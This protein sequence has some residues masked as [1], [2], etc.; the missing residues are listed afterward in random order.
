MGTKHRCAAALLLAVFLLFC[1]ACGAAPVQPEDTE[2]KDQYMTDPVP[3]GKPAP[4]E[5]QDVV[6]DDDAELTCTF[7]ISCATILDN[8]DKC[9]DSKKPLVPADGVIL[10]STTVTLFALIPGVAAY[11]KTLAMITVVAIITYLSLII[12]ELVPKSIALNNPERWA[13]M[14]SP[15]MIVL[16]K[17]SYPFVCLLSASTKLMNKLIGLNSGEERQMTQ[18]ELKMIL[19]QSSEQG[20]IDKDETEM[21]RDVFRFSDKRA[22]DLMTYRRDIVVLHPTD[23]PEEVLRIIHEEHFSKYLLVERGKDE[24]IGVVSVKDIILMMGGEQPFNLRSIARPALF[25]PESLYAKKVLELF[26]KNKNKF[27]VVVDEYGNTEGIITLHDLTESI[28]GDILEENETEEEEIVVRQDGSMLVEASMNLD[29]FMEAMGIMNYDDLKEE[30]FTTLSGLAMF[31][32]GQV[33]KAGDLFSYKNLDF[34]VVDMDRG[35]VDK[36]LVI[37]KE[38]DE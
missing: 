22:N 13:T 33:P 3:E 20:V 37:K 8:W 30:D 16:T 36:L 31:L 35:R 24:I 26:K 2:N 6:R 10:P 29:D 27:G 1:T 38:E 7:S 23:T 19:H 34:E 21:L 17:I 32:I 15:F 4:V 5:P 14:L 11:A 9:D 28:F 25:I 12:G 18:D